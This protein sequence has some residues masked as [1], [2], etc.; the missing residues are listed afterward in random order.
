MML[1]VSRN[2]RF[3][4]SLKE[5]RAHCREKQEKQ[6][7]TV[8]TWE[9]ENFHCLMLILLQKSSL[10]VRNSVFSATGAK[11]K[12]QHK[13]KQEPQTLLVFPNILTLPPGDNP[14]QQLADNSQRLC[15]EAVL[16]H[17]AVPTSTLIFKND[18]RKN[19][20]NRDFMLMFNSFTGIQHLTF[21]LPE[22]IL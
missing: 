4:W 16:W 22:L 10:C 20:N 21:A 5:E 1:W 7:L 2:L 12:D 3:K 8:H 18:N 13:H 14:E 19:Y 9:T 15:W 17:R 6:R 11:L